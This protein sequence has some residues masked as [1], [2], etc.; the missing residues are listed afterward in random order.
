MGVGGERE[1]VN[2]SWEW[3]IFA[4]HQHP[5]A[6]LSSVPVHIALDLS[7]SLRPELLVLTLAPRL[8]AMAE[9]TTRKSTDTQHH[10]ILHHSKSNNRRAGSAGLSWDEPNLEEN[11]KIKAALPKC[12]ISEPK[13]PYHTLLPDE[14]IELEP[15]A[16]DGQDAG[17]MQLDAVHWITAPPANLRPVPVPNASMRARTGVGEGSLGI[18]ALL[19]GPEPTH[20]MPMLPMQMPTR[21]ARVRHSRRLGRSTTG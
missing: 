5:F 10:G 6:K 2:V 9:A 7:C 18:P 8:P 11:E 3:A 19:H 4:L 13:T 21:R 20:A 14:D 15:L 17:A 12:K 1:S 16:L